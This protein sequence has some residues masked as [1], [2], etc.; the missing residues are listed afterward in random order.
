MRVASPGQGWEQGQGDVQSEAVP[1]A[2]VLRTVQQGTRVSRV[3]AAKPFTL[4]LWLPSVHSGQA[5]GRGRQMPSNPSSTVPGHFPMASSVFPTPA[6]PCASPCGATRIQV[7]FIWLAKSLGGCGGAVV[8]M[9]TMAQRGCRGGLGDGHG[10]H[11]RDRVGTGAHGD[12]VVG[13]RWW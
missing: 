8:G 9:V 2:L 10:G 7:R 11:S 13:T 1:P 6:R 12:G 4:A 3:L 5:P